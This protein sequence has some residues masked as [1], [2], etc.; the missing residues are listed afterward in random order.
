MDLGMFDK[1]YPSLKTRALIEERR[2]DMNRSDKNSERYVIPMHRENVWTNKWMQDPRKNFLQVSYHDPSVQYRKGWGSFKRKRGLT[3]CYSCRRPGHLAK[4]CPGKRPSC[5]CCKAL[6]HEVLD[7]PR[8]IAKVERMNMNQENPK[9]DPETE[10]MTEPQK[11]SEKV[12][13]QM[14]ETLNDH[15]HV[16][17]SE[18]F[19]EKEYIEARI[20]DFDID[21]VLDEETQVNIMTER[22]WEILGKPAMIPSLGGIGLFRGKLITLCGRLTRI[23]MSAHGTSTEEEFEVVKFIENN[24]PFVML[25]G[26]PWIEKDQARRKEEEILEQKKQELKY[27]MTRRIAHLIE[28][29]ENQAKLFPTRDLD[30]EVGRTLEDPQKTEVPIPGTDEVLPLISRKEPQQ[31][32]VT[33]PK[34]DKNQNGKRNSR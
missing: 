1:I 4:E 2:F 9:A 31:R 12:L 24:A 7:F 3:L 19:K 10:I 34:E 27:F 28:E 23:S 33:L 6:D 30:V 15:R 5:L 13:L 8:M 16:S 22:T 26:K 20:G 21:C 29:Q 14:Q 18:V 17:L 11:G 32:E 25:L